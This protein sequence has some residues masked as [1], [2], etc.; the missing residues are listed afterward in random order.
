MPRARPVRLMGHLGLI[1]LFCKAGSHLLVP[2]AGGG[3]PGQTSPHRQGG[4]GR[5]R[6]VCAVGGRLGF[7]GRRVCRQRLVSSLWHGD[8]CSACDI[9]TLAVPQSCTLLVLVHVHSFNQGFLSV[10]AARFY[11][12]HWMQQGTGHPS[13]L[14]GDRRTVERKTSS[15]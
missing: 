2:S 11:R 4:Q 1:S 5:Q 9:M 13:C 6:K 7:G 15:N 12:R 10:S 3:W 14:P 8:R